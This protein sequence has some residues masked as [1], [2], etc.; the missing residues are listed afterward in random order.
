MAE[1]RKRK[2]YE[3]PELERLDGLQTVA[4]EPP[5]PHLSRPGGGCA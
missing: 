5:P 3:R 4:A 2:Q 1:Q